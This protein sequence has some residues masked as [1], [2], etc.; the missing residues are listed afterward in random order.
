M[1]M[2]SKLS[3]AA[4]CLTLILAP[5]PACARPQEP[6]PPATAG[7]LAKGFAPVVKRALPAVVNISTSR[8][9]RTPEGDLPSQ[10]FSD[11]FFRRFFGDEIPEFNVP[12]E[13]R[14]RS[15]GSGVIVSP[16]GY[17]LTN[18]HVIDRASDILVALADKREFQARV[19]GQ[20]SKTDVAVLKID[21]RD[22][23]VLPFGD[24][25]RMEPGDLVLAIGN[26][27]GLSQTVT[28]GIVSAVGRGGLG[29]EE[30]EDFIQTDAAINPGNSGGALINHAGELIGINTAIVSGLGGGNQG[31]GFAVPINMARGVLEQIQKHGKVIRAWLG[32]TIQPVTPAIAK[33]FGLQES[34][35]ALVGDVSADSPAARS[36]IQ[37]GDVILE[38]EGQRIEN[39]RALQL[40]IGSMTPGTE[41]TLKIFRNGALT[42]LRVSLGEMPAAAEQ[43]P[44]R[45]APPRAPT[46]GISVGPLTPEILRQLQLPAGTTGVVIVEVRPASPAEEAGLER[47]DVIQEVNRRPVNTVA[48][49]EEA[50]RQ[51]AG[52]TVLLLVNRRGSTRFVPLEL[53]Q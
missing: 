17:I 11:P 36:G 4:L 12:R 5:A 28:M 15:L 42:D 1:A 32:V 50:I 53:R 29:I 33:A 34:Y 26:P 8:I 35:G 23:P 14:E 7:D 20:D 49:Y 39:S 51:A 9:V 48:Q 47:G 13:R 44:G 6:G 25:A 10:L 30:Y 37:R 31:I 18:H 16:D 24:S 21:A 38:V 40:K 41:V 52:Q 19:V 43:A 22:L 27:F 3:R 46:G 45:T 2:I